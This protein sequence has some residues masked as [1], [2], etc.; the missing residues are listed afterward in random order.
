[1]T[2]EEIR[3]ANEK[4]RKEMEDAAKAE[5]EQNEA[6]LAAEKEAA[7]EAER[8]A[9]EEAAKSKTQ[10]ELDAEEAAK[11][12]ESKSLLDALSMTI[13]EEKEEVVPEKVKKQL[14][15]L[16]SEKNEL[17]K[18]LTSLESDPLVKAVT[19]EATK[20]QLIAIAAELSGKD[21]SKSSYK[22]LLEAEIRSLGFEGEE[23]TEQLE[24]E[25]EK[26]ESLLPYQ[27][28]KVE[29]EM[30]DKFQSNVKKGES[31]TLANLEAAYQEKMKSVETPEQ[32]KAKVKAIVEADKAA[33]KKV[34]ENAIGTKLYGIEFTKQELNDILEKEYTPEKADLYANEKGELNV[35]KFIVD[36]FK[37]RNLD[38]MIE[39]AREEGKK[40]SNVVAE[41]ARGQA[42]TTVSKGEVLTDA[43]KNMKAMGFP[44]HIWRNAK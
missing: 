7:E 39:L 24:A 2:L 31:P 35:S 10:E 4:A 26:F 43:Q 6:K 22:D 25:L 23:L 11:Q 34:G 32:Y 14:E 27:K 1:M 20:E 44:E 18:K 3:E 9:A 5:Q 38:K 41:A 29:K 19:A 16:E 30:R 40:S 8:L 13:E 42:R 33:I 28:R 36:T 17:A 15:Q 37:L 21:Y 12:N